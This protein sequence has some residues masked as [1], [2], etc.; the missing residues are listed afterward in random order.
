MSRDDLVATLFAEGK[1]YREIGAVLGVSRQRAH[2][3]CI[4]LGLQRERKPK[5]FNAPHRPSRTRSKTDLSYS[6]LR[7]LLSYDQETGIFRW[8]V[9]RPRSKSEVAGYRNNGGYTQIGIDGKIYMAHVLAWFYVH[10]RWPANQLDHRN[11]DRSDNRI[12]NLRLASGSENCGNSPTRGGKYKGV[13]FDKA[14]GK[15]RAEI[16]HIK[17]GRYDTPEQA[18]EAYERAARIRYGEFARV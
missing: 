18:A 15:W 12:D 7:E 13:W 8:L 4:E 17:I 6:R 14:S 9:K 11:R 10:E 16:A 5:D 3:I 1:K 2:Q